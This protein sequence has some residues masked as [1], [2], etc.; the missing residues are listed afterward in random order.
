MDDMAIVVLLFVRGETFRVVVGGGRE[1]A[2]FDGFRVC[3]CR[4]D[5]GRMELCTLTIVTREEE[6]GS[7]DANK[8]E[9][10]KF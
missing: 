5:Y 6:D 8:C 4:T 1:C 3:T 9:T 7:G 2:R 10:R